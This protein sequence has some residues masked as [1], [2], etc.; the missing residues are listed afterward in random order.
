MRKSLT[1]ALLAAGSLVAGGSGTVCFAEEAANM[2]SIAAPAQAS[3]HDMQQVNSDEQ[4]QNKS[5]EDQVQADD[6]AKEQTEEQP[7]EPAGAAIQAVAEKVPSPSQRDMRQQVR[8][9]QRNMAPI[10]ANH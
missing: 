10:T 9:A 6:S 8:E 2:P 4:S 7:Q 3:Q 1:L 5:E